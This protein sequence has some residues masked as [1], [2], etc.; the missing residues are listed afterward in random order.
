MP[1]HEDYELPKGDEN[2]LG[3]ATRSL[4]DAISHGH[5]SLLGR[6]RAIMDGFPFTHILHWVNVHIN[7]FIKISRF[8]SSICRWDILV[9]IYDDI[10]EI[11]AY[12]YLLTI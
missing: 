11:V 2:I 4:T 1:L 12:F 9:V 6:R 3:R 10:C 8:L 7:E 5:K